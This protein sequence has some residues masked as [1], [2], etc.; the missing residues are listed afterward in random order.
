[1]LQSEHTRNSC[2][3]GITLFINSG[4]VCLQ[5]VSHDSGM[6]GR[7]NRIDRC[8]LRGVAYNH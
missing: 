6:I 8:C 4:N 3:S 7:V 2:G 1:M 5:E